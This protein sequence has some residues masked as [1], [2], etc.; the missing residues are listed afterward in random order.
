MFLFLTRKK[1][2]FSLLQHIA[3]ETTNRFKWL[4]T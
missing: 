2:L 1:L 4:C 3:S